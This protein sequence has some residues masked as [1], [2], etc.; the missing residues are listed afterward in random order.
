GVLR[1]AFGLGSLLTKA[2]AISTEII[3]GQG[4][5]A[6]KAAVEVIVGGECLAVA[7]EGWTYL[8]GEHGPYRKGTVRIARQA[9]EQLA[10][11]IKIVPIFL[12]YDRYP[13][14]WVRKVGP[15]YE[16]FF[17]ILAAW[18][19]RGGVRVVIGEPISSADLPGDDEQAT[20]Y[21]RERIGALD[22]GVIS[23]AGAPLCPASDGE[24]KS[25][26]AQSSGQVQA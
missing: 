24:Y 8:D 20:A 21:L 2:G 14:K 15:P 5:P 10:R 11:P 22:P 26:Q 7:P 18:Y 13:S 19:Y 12:R 16:Y 17:M 9:S 1:F 4:G 6:I 23:E 3:P 25:L